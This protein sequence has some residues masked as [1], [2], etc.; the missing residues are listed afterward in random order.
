MR[1]SRLGVAFWRMAHLFAQDAASGALPLVF[2]AVSPDVRGGEYIG[3]GRLFGLRGHP[4][5]VRSSRS[6]RDAATAQR[7]WHASEDLTGVHF[8][9]PEPARS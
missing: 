4:V 2:A 9:L 8:D 1:G 7:L 6:S 3:P 5:H